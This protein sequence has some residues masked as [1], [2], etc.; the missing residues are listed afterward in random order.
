MEAL[1]RAGGAHVGHW[2]SKTKIVLLVK[3]FAVLTVDFTFIFFPSQKYFFFT[4]G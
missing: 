4:V 3:V 2:R 1:L